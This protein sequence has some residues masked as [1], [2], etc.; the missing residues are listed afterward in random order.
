MVVLAQVRPL[1]PGWAVLFRAATA[2]SSNGKN[3][4]MQEQV[5]E[6]RQQGP[7]GTALQGP[8]HG[9]PCVVDDGVT[10]VTGW[11]RDGAALQ[12]WKTIGRR[13]ALRCWSSQ[14]QG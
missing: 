7:Q 12:Q 2:V 14:R 3:A 13:C 8:F 1:A 9:L 10:L 5:A 6:G 11:G 4:Q